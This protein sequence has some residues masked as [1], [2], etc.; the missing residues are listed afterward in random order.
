MHLIGRHDPEF[1]GKG[2]GKPEGGGK[3]KPEGGRGEGKPEGG[4][5]KGKPEG[6]KAKGKDAKTPFKGILKNPRPTIEADSEDG[7][8]DEDSDKEENAESECVYYEGR[9]NMR[10]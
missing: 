1:Q 4:R 5:G 9:K 3:G 8:G 7:G 6:G 10:P 2:K